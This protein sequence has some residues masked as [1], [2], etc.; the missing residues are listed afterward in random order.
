MQEDRIPKI[1]IS[2]SWSSDEKVVPLATRLMSH[3]VDVVL[4]KWEV[5]EGQDKY[6]F[7]E[8]CV[9]DPSIT[10]VLIICDKEYAN[11]ANAR[12]G[13]VGDE[14]AIISNEIYDRI[15]QEKFIPIIVERDPEGKPYVPTYIKSR[16]YID[17]SDEEKY[18]NEYEKL[19]R[20]VYE[21]PLYNK[22]KL[23]DR[24]D[25]MDEESVNLFPLTDLLKQIRGTRFEKKQ[26]SCIRSFIDKYIELLKPYKEKSIGNGEEIYKCFIEMKPIR[27]LFLDF[28]SVLSETTID[29]ADIMGDTFEILYNTLTNVKYFN[30]N[31][32]RASDNDYEI[33]KICIWELFICVIA[34]LRHV[35]DYKAINKLLT[36]TYFLSSSCLDVNVRPANYCH[37][38]FYSCMVEERYKP[39]TEER[40]KFT[41]L[42][43]TIYT[44]REKKPIYTGVALADADLFLYQVSKAYEFL[45][46]NRYWGM[47]FWF[48]Q[49]Y[50]YA[51]KCLLEWKKIISRKY[52]EKMFDLFGVNNLDKL[53]EVLANCTSERIGYRG[54]F[55]YVPAIL[56]CIKLEE[57]GSLN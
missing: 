38:Y 13:G 7:M 41:L 52:C 31:A 56:D 15:N 10:K 25:W 4:D 20:N 2:Y 18:E 29:F 16:I 33:Y 55:D 49:L 11:K 21:K 34:F 36:R 43:H 35:Q 26:E 27:D 51:N 45:N 6:A 14:T 30:P 9:N 40:D 57:I 42:G 24:P 46:D 12:T 28:I 39:Y 32:Q 1:F 47:N 48:P 17:L 3:G 53:K 37:F 44:Q 50:V 23:G 5:K 54:S 22:P 8:R 19:L